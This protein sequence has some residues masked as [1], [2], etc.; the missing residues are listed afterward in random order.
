MQLRVID[1]FRG[2]RVLSALST[3]PP[4]R[5]ISLSPLVANLAGRRLSLLPP[6]SSLAAA[7]TGG[8]DDPRTGLKLARPQAKRPICAPLATLEP[9]VAL[10]FRVNPEP[11]AGLA[12]PVHPQPT[13]SSR[14]PFH[15]S[16]ILP[17]WGALSG[18]TSS[19]LPSLILPLHLHAT[20]GSP[21]RVSSSTPSALILAFYST[22]PRQIALAPFLHCSSFFCP[23]LTV[24]SSASL[25][26]YPSLRPSVRPSVH[27]SI[28]PS[29]HPSSCIRPI[30]SPPGQLSVEVPFLRPTRGVCPFYALCTR[31]PDSFLLCSSFSN[32]VSSS[33]SNHHPSFIR[34]PLISPLLVA[35]AGS[36]VRALLRCTVAHSSPLTAS[37]VPTSSFTIY[38][39]THTAVR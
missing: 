21:R 15:G 13:Q 22:S 18:P 10:G 24:S 16:P 12:G 36:L 31:R 2:T 34:R 9:E 27:P 17:D 20:S 7:R 25:F 8:D 39:C 37:I 26:V 38:A 32:S 28:H 11:P 14:S 33:S 29:I 1:A 30:I 3:L 23:F 19:L 6:S 35:S 4:E 5:R